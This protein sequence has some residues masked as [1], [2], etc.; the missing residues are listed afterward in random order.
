[1][2]YSAESF[3]GDHQTLM[4]EILGGYRH[5]LEEELDSLVKRKE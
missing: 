5:V 4:K 1:M 3:C 2:I